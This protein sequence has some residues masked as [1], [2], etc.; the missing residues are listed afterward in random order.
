MYVDKFRNLDF[1]EHE[2]DE[3]TK[4][5]ARMIEIREK[6]IGDFGKVNQHFFGDE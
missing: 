5:E 4:H 6:Q 1:V 2:L 3:Y